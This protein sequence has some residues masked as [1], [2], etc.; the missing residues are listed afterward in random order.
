MVIFN[1]VNAG[2]KEKEDFAKD[3]FPRLIKEKQKIAAY[4]M[5]NGVWIDI[6]RLDEYEKLKDGKEIMELLNK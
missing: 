1:H 6:G 4:K 2:I 5:E 3:V